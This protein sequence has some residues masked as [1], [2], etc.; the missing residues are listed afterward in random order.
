MKKI[1]YKKILIIVL[2]FIGLSGLLSSLA[3]VGNKE[4][5]II[6]KNLAIHVINTDENSFIDEQD[7]LNY[8]KERNDSILY[9]SAKNIDIN[10]IEKALNTHPSIKNSEV[11]IDINGDVEIKITQRSPI[12]RV[13]NLDG[14]SY[15]IDDD[16]KAMPLNDKYTARVL[17][18]NGFV[19]E[20]YTS[21]YQYTIEDILNH[22]EL[23]K[24]S[25]L[26]DIYVLANYITKDTLLNNLIHQ[27]YITKEKQIELFPSIG[28]H[29]IMFGEAVDIEEKF[30]KLKLFYT[31][32]LNKTNSWNKY[33]TINIKYKNQV[34]CTKK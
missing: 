24:A 31:E 5:N 18:A 8:F 1:N 4:K 34:V 16:T 10:K 27:I 19:F 21:I 3:F 9:N 28:N 2:W 11:S 25:S 6:S 12:V 26:D 17:I 32:G 15:Y 29:K 13:I 7:V 22:E 20:P 30:N 33:S 14:E 23:K